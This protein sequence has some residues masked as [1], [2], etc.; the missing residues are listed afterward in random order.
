MASQASRMLPVK[1][2]SQIFSSGRKGLAESVISRSSCRLVGAVA[3]ELVS[4]FSPN[5][6]KPVAAAPRE[7][8]PDRQT[9]R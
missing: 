8:T 5:N 6:S 7:A 4:S 1:K 9:P 3:V 2:T